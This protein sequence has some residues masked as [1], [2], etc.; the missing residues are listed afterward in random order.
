[1]EAL[2]KAAIAFVLMLPSIVV[3]EVCL[4]TQ[5]NSVCT[6]GVC[7]EYRTEATAFSVGTS[8]GISYWLTCAHGWEGSSVYIHGNGKRNR[9]SIVHKQQDVLYDYAILKCAGFV[10]DESYCLPEQ[11]FPPG[12]NKCTIA[13][14]PGGVAQTRVTKF[15]RKSAK[16]NNEQHAYGVDEELVPGW[17]GGPALVQV[18]GRKYA[19]G[20][21][22]YSN[23]TVTPTYYI[24]NAVARYVSLDCATPYEA[25]PPPEKGWQD[26]PCPEIPVDKL[27]PVPGNGSE[28]RQELVKIEK[29]LAEL[30]IKITK[31]EAKTDSTVDGL[32]KLT[33]IV[34]ANAQWLAVK[35]PKVDELSDRLK[36][37]ESYKRIV[38]TLS[39][40][41]TVRASQEYGWDDPIVLEPVPVEVK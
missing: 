28:D 17:S 26:A 39:V 22:R 6:N 30:Q 14:F 3:G 33:S 34:E 10:P 24:R 18:N 13:G 29:Q 40:D 23:G 1:V 36:R 38:K 4:V 15:H 5:V 32:S 19:L 9:A 25:P 7:R 35:G 21:I 11:V 16:L 37:L 41:G 2:T 27:P 20:V 31:L 12:S 8:G